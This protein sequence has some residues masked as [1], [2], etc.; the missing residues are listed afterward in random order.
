MQS[1]F[2]P[3]QQSSFTDGHVFWVVVEFQQS[4][5]VVKFLALVV[6]I[7]VEISPEQTSIHCAIDTLVIHCNF[8][9]YK[10]SFCANE[11][12]E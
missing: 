2:F 1:Y 7:V 6:A 9:L 12:A 11:A 3:R 4:W 5:V 10:F 8:T